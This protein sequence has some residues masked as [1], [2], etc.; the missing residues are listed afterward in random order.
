[1]SNTVTCD[2]CGATVPAATPDWV[3]LSR[4]LPKDEGKPDR[5]YLLGIDR[6]RWDTCSTS[7]AHKL[8]D[9]MT[10]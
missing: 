2:S 4:N 9:G 10:H 1:M 6:D 3:H 7:C 5:L 8:L